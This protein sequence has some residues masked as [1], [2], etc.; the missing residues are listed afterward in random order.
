MRGISVLVLIAVVMSAACALKTRKEAA[1]EELQ[2]VEAQKA[3]DAS[4]AHAITDEPSAEDSEP[5]DSDDPVLNEELNAVQSQPEKAEAAP[6]SSPV[7]EPIVNSPT[8]KAPVK[9]AAKKTPA[10]PAKKAAAKKKP[11]AKKTA[12]KDKKSKKLAK[13]TAK[14]K[15]GKKSAGDAG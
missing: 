1:E 7:P 3:E 11:S 12:S 14:K 6:S 2:K 15:P 4:V 9:K 13:K 8:A 5:I 10:K